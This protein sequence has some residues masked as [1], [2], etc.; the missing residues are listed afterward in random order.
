MANPF[1]DPK[2]SVTIH[3]STASIIKILA[4]L[5]LLGFLYLVWDVI[6]IVFIALLFAASLG[7][8]I[9]WLEKKKIPRPAG[10]LLIYSTV[11]LFLSLVVVLI[12]PAIT[13]Q[14]Q[15][16]AANSPFYYQRFLEIIG[17]LQLKTDISQTLQ[18]NLENVSQTLSSYTGSIINTITGIFG[19]ILVFVMVLVLTFYFSVSKNGL[20]HFIYSVTPEKHQK[21]AINLFERIQDKLG[22]WL[23]GQ[24][25]LSLIIFAITWIGL[26][27]LDVR[28]ALVLAL[29]AGFTEVIPYIGPVIGA[30]PAV[31]LTFLQSPVKALLVIAL[32]VVIQQLENNII[33][34][35]VMQRAVGLNPVVVIIVL[36]LGAKL[37]GVIGALLAIPL[38]V[39]I[40][41]VAKDWFGVHMHEAGAGDSREHKL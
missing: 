32:Y 25:L 21:Y 8:A 10:I 33:V 19:G 5:L 36:L 35:K 12:I 41:V 13:D 20:R 6:V 3:I 22:L 4:V 1:N 27:I 14:I 29:I 9:D 31:F 18:Q 39:A 34:P 2:D 26:L 7:P 16:L 40:M 37:A 15:Q 28:Y 11:L 17:D 38:A 23:R 30:V 24:L